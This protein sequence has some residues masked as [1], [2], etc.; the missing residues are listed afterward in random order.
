MPSP[1]QSMSPDRGAS[2]DVP[3]ELNCIFLKSLIPL[4]EQEVGQRGSRR[5]VPRRRASRA[6]G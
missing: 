1:A 3:G 4:V 6:S 2:G 5:I